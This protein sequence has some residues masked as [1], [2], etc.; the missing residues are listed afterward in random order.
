MPQSPTSHIR[1]EYQVRPSGESLGEGHLV[2]GLL[3]LFSPKLVFKTNFKILSKANISIIFSDVT[4]MA[5]LE[6]R[7]ETVLH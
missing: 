5:S 6:T 3:E 4:K 1:E 7:W 2:M